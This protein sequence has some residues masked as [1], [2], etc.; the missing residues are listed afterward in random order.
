LYDSQVGHAISCRRKLNSI[1]S[2]AQETEP[3]TAHPTS[4]ACRL[5]KYVRR[6]RLQIT[7]ASLVSFGLIAGV[8]G[9]A[10]GFFQAKKQEGI[11]LEQKRNAVEESEAKAAALEREQKARAR[12]NEARDQAKNFFPRRWKLSKRG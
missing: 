8:A 4:L 11:A 5:R 2:G 12:E 6:H 9:L 1:A 10:F 7:A 3:A